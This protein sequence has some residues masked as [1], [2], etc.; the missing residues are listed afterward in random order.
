MDFSVLNTEKDGGSSPFL[1]QTISPINQNLKVGGET[2][3]LQ[4]INIKLRRGGVLPPEKFNK[5]KKRTHTV[6]PY[7]VCANIV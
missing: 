2:P 7:V 1:K 4:K 3:P 6:R 5:R